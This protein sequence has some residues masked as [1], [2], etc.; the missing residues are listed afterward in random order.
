MN[1]K[2]QGMRVV[3]TGAGSGVGWRI[4]QV[5]MENEARVHISDIREDYL[6]TCKAAFP[7]V[8]TTVD[9]GKLSPSICL[10]RVDQAR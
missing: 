9:R 2:L 8:G 6:S 1:I 7:N 3:I 5:F 10:T 4:A